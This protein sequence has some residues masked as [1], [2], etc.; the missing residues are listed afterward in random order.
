MPLSDQERKNIRETWRIKVEKDREIE[1]YRKKEAFDRVYKIAKILK[2]KYFVDKVI[3]YGSLARDD[4]FDNLSDIDIF[5][6]GWDDSKF[7]YWTMLIDVENVAKP[8]KISIVTQKEAYKSLLNE[9]LREGR[10]IE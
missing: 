9:I 7:N 4:R 8:Y 3:L 10:I 6:D 1:T 5:I 2:E